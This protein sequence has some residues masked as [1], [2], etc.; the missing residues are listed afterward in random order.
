M[1]TRL[2]WGGAGQHPNFGLGS[3]VC[4]GESRAGEQP[5]WEPSLVGVGQCPLAGPL[6]LRWHAEGG[7]GPESGQ[8]TPEGAGMAAVGREVFPAPSAPGPSARRLGRPAPAPRPHSPLPG[9]PVGACNTTGAGRGLACCASHSCSGEFLAAP[10]ARPWSG[11]CTPF[12][13]ERRLGGGRPPSRCHTS[14]GWS[15]LR[16][17]LRGGPCPLGWLPGLDG[18]P[19]G[20]RLRPTWN[21]FC[22]SLARAPFPYDLEGGNPAGLCPFLAISG[23]LGRLVPGRRGM[24]SGFRG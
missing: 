16:S 20:T 3:W 17:G 14:P 23:G 8:R 24:A 5:A 22:G 9:R 21:S 15:W 1:K 12:P 13:G 10:R 6:P 4:A 19:R 7:T 11:V 18:P 2:G